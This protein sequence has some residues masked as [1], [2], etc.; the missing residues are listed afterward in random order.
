MSVNTCR[1]RNLTTDGRDG[2]RS[3]NDLAGLLKLRFLSLDC[4]ASAP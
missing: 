2:L 1:L 4:S 3:A